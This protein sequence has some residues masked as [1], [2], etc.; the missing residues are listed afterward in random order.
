M[1]NAKLK[2][3]TNPSLLAFLTFSVITPVFT[4]PTVG[5]P[6]VKKMII[7]VRLVR[8]NS[9]W[10]FFK[11][12]TRASLILVPP[13]ASMRRIKFLASLMDSSETG[14]AKISS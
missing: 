3:D 11:A 5:S 8:D 2:M 12:R 9:D 14:Y 10:V 1:P 4:S 13:L 6:S 7:G